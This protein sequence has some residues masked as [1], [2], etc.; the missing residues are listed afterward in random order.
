MSLAILVTALAILL[1]GFAC[2]WI[3]GRWWMWRRSPMN[4]RMWLVDSVEG[5]VVSVSVSSAQVKLP[6]INCGDQVTIDYD[7]AEE[8]VKP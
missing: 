6:A 1:G 2:G 3:A 5:S 4:P 8:V 7:T